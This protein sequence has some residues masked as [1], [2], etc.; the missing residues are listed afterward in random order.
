MRRSDLYTTV[1]KAIRGLLYELGSKMQ[2]NDFTDDTATRELP[3][4]LK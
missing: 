1:H 3:A 2:R 4:Q